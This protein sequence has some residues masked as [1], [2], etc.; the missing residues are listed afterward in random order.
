MRMICHFISHLPCTYVS[1]LQC[2]HQRIR[3]CWWKNA[4]VFP[5]EQRLTHLSPPSVL[6]RNVFNGCAAF[7]SQLLTPVWSAVQIA[8]TFRPYIIFN[9]PSVVWLDFNLETWSRCL[10]RAAPSEYWDEV[11]S[12]CLTLVPP[13]SLSN[14]SILEILYVGHLKDYW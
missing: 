7:S 8:I 12:I 5:A 14:S 3:S 13:L 10:T 4:T 2:C 6:W 1:M 9:L 11:M